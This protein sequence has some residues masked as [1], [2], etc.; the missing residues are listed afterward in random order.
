[1]PPTEVLAA[2]QGLLP[3]LPP[4]EAL[5]AKQGHSF[6]LKVGAAGDG[7][8]SSKAS[9]VARVGELSLDEL[10]VLPERELPPD[11]LLAV[12]DAVAAICKA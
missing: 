9:L 6:D 8:S 7:G 1:M 3:T 2:K 5:T 4:A 12:A 11:V 10:M